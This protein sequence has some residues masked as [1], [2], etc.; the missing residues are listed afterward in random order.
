M[1]FPQWIVMADEKCILYNN[2]GY[3]QNESVNCMKGSF[4]SKGMLYLYMVG[5]V[6]G[7][8]WEKYYSQLDKL[9]AGSNL[10]KAFGIREKVILE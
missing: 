4:H 3:K 1:F 2:R 6:R 9:K 10:W 7:F 8:L 5:M